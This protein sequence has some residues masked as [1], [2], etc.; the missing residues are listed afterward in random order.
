MN[1][2]SDATGSDDFIVQIDPD[3]ADLIPG[4]LE[5]RR[6][7]VSSLRQALAN[8][9]FQAVS[10]IGHTMKGAGAGYGFAT[11]SE[12][13]AALEQGGPAGDA[14]PLIAAVDRLDGYLQNVTVV[15]E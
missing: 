11:I 2:H 10:F 8:S 13:G 4:F 15:F 1:H 6:R 5:N 12:I 7:D 3:I 9:D 14:V